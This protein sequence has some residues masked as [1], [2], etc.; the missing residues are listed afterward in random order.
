MDKRVLPEYQRIKAD[1][2]I[3]YRNIGELF[4]ARTKRTPMKEFLISPGKRSDI[5]SYKDFQRD[6]LVVAKFLR[7]KGLRK[8][9]RISLV[10][11]NSPKFLLIYFGALTSGITVVPINHDL[12]PTEMLYIIQNSGSKVVFYN[13]DFDHKIEAIR[14]EIGE[15]P[16]LIGLHRLPDFEPLTAELGTQ[17][18][19]LKMPVVELTDEA[20]IIY[21]SG[22]TGAPKGVILTHLN[23]LADAKAVS[24]WFHFSTDTRTLC[25]LP[26]FHNNGQVVTL[27]APLYA[28]GST[29]VVKGK[30][31]LLPFWGL[32]AKYDVTWTSVMPS[33]LSI[34]LSLPMERKDKTMC[35]IICGGQVLSRSVQDGFEERF[36]V[37]IFEG[38]GLTET[39]S[40]ACYN[41][42]PAENRRLGTIGLPL[43][44]NEMAIMDE[45]DNELGSNV[46]GEICI[47]GLNVTSGYLGLP[48]KNQEAFANGWFH[49]GDFGHRD[50]DG[51]YYFHT[52]KDALIIKRGE[53]I[54]PAEL[55]NILY[56]HPAIAECAVV[57]IPDKVSG[58]E[59]CAFVKLRKDTEAT[60]EDLRRFC[61]G[62]IAAFKQAKEFIIINELDDLLEIPKGP[63]KKVLYRKLR[64]YY[65]YKKDIDAER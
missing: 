32:V 12:A 13:Y 8:G 39:T 54:Y 22:T 31:S 65:I 42:Y 21:T 50:E 47:R 61:T 58:E 59:I 40:F 15:D 9:D 17:E 3:E 16:L 27:L 55:E 49:S 14:G 18:P 46:E 37:P 30:A 25:I 19:E 2:D 26:L 6:F 62:K 53:N 29:V 35:G 41:K 36:G 44:V 24:E 33:I 28:G 56:Q 52:R 20:V 5:F 23:L 64:E 4:Q 38:F 48:Q 43:P 51:Y 11:S 63:T 7:S 10:I 45:H 60:E 1:V 34:L 57:G